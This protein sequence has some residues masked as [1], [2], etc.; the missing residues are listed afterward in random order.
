MKIEFGKALDNKTWRFLIPCLRGYGDTFINKFNNEIFKLAYGINDTILEGSKILEGKRPIYTMI[1]TAVLPRQFFNFME[2]VKYQPYY[3]TDYSADDMGNSRLHML[4]LEVPEEFQVAYDK[5][6][7]GLYSEM[8][9]KEQLHDLFKDKTNTEQYNILS[10]NPKYSDI[11]LKRVEDEFSVRM[12]GLDKE[13]F[14]STA[15]YEF[16]YSLDSEHEIFNT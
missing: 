12:K 8:Y 16:P 13:I 5:F 9:T 7:I 14:I 6:C 11:F 1:D 10:R 4:V 15:E 3:I 2:W